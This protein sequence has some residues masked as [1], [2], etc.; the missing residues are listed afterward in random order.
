V[1]ERRALLFCNFL[2]LPPLPLWCKKISSIVLGSARRIFLV[3]GVGVCGNLR[4]RKGELQSHETRLHGGEEKGEES[5]GASVA[6]ALL[7]C[8]FLAT[9]SESQRPA[10][11]FRP[12]CSPSHAKSRSLLLWHFEF[13]SLC[14]FGEPACCL[15]LCSFPLLS[16]EMEWSEPAVTA[17]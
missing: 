2:T 8:I 15:F 10:S 4:Q 11:H 16:S 5:N 6:A 7:P 14:F 12:F 17:R 1:R 3:R 13:F 9:A